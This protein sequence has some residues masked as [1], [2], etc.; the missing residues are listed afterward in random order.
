MRTI[1]A[2]GGAVCVVTGASAGGAG[3]I[4]VRVNTGIESVGSTRAVGAVDALS[5]AVRAR[6]AIGVTS[7]MSV[8]AGV[9][10]SAGTITVR[11]NTGVE[12]VGS[13]RAVGAVNAL[14]SAVSA[15]VSAGV[16]TGGVG[17]SGGEVATAESVGLGVT[18]AISGLAAVLAVAGNLAVGAVHVGVY[19]GI[20]SV[21]SAGVVRAGSALRGAVVSRV[22]AVDS[23]L[24][25]VDD[26]GHIG[27]CSWVLGTCWGYNIKFEGVSKCCLVL[28]VMIVGLVDLSVMRNRKYELRSGED[29]VLY[30]PESTSLFRLRKTSGKGDN[31][32]KREPWHHLDPV[33][34]RQPRLTRYRWQAQVRSAG[35]EASDGSTCRSCLAM[36]AGRVCRTTSEAGNGTCSVSGTRAHSRSSCP[37]SS[38]VR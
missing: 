6:R 8:V 36:P 17:A 7:A 21:G 4:T 23:L 30:M 5:S 10:G 12:S 9:A 20:G 2:L 11:V 3:T 13:T 38:S 34:G 26:A 16:G 31:G 27:C 22:V 25:L 19:S 29:G 35:N 33:L 1:G 37:V 14:S 15:R 24:D 28:I 32:V 18:T